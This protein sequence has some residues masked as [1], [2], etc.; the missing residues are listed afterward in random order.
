MDSQFNNECDHEVVLML[1]QHCM[2]QSLHKYNFDK[3][4]SSNKSFKYANLII[5]G[6]VS[7]SKFYDELNF[8]FKYFANTYQYIYLMLFPKHH[9]NNDKFVIQ[10]KVQLTMLYQNWKTNKPSVVVMPDVVIDTSKMG[11]NL[12]DFVR[13]VEAFEQQPIKID[14]IVPSFL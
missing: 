2:Q 5:K 9:V 1:L 14:E 11:T 7:I 8:Y 12:I 13:K 10:N 3:L 4:Y 6:F